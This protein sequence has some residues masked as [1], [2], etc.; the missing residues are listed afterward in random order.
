MSLLNHQEQTLFIAVIMI[1]VA[2]VS[3]MILMIYQNIHIFIQY[4]ASLLAIETIEGYTSLVKYF[5]FVKSTVVLF[6]SIFL[7]SLLCHSYFIYTLI[8]YL[9]LTTLWGMT[10]VL[11]IK[12]FEKK[13][14]IHLLKGTF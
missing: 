1:S 7:I 10:Y 6:I 5:Y 8:I 12:K 11:S 14:I 3:L 4:H 9:I 2:L 13:N